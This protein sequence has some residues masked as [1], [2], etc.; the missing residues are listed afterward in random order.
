MRTWLRR[1]DGL[2]QQWLRVLVLAVAVTP[3]TAWAAVVAMVT[4]LQGKAS[5]VESG[6]ARSVNILAELEAGVQVQLQAGATLVV[7]YLDGGDEYVLKGPALA[8]FR[9]GQPEVVNGLKAEKRSPALGNGVRIKPVGMAQGAVVLRSLM[10]GA[11]IRLLSLNGTRVLETEPEFRWQEM[12]PGLKYEFALS[13][14]T[15]RALFETQVEGAALKLPANLPLKDGASYRWELSARL[16]DGRRYSNAAVFSIATPEL[17]AQAVAFRSGAM[18]AV[19]ARVSY[20]AWL[21]QVELKDEARKYWRALSSE[22][23]DDERL[24]ALAEQ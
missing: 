17:R 15:G 3:F 10:P 8:V 20:A 22:R 18:A 16:P 19:S 12:Q 1:L 5:I 7:L 6:V 2:W 4:D 21:D 24:K 9:T 11:R 14:D 13:D 23:P